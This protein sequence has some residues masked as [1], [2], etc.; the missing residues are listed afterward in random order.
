M[1]WFDDLGDE[2]AIKALGRFPALDH[3]SA[4]RAEAALAL[5]NI[6]GEAATKALELAPE[7]RV[8]SK[9]TRG[10]RPAISLPGTEG[11][12]RFGRTDTRAQS[13]KENCQ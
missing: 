13:M 11:Y 2:S 12:G 7:G 5:G 9:A 10:S 8:R 3:Q 6:G 1:Q 4:I